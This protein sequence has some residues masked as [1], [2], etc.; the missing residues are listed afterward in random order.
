MLISPDSA[1]A[2]AAA[3]LQLNPLL[4]LTLIWTETHLQERDKE[5][6]GKQHNEQTKSPKRASGSSESATPL[7][8]IK[9][10]EWFL[11][12]IFLHSIT[13]PIF[14]I[15]EP[16]TIAV[17]A[18]LA[19]STIWLGI[20]VGRI[21]STITL[22]GINRILFWLTITTAWFPLW[23]LVLTIHVGSK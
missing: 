18:S 9:R 5:R 12:L 19:I 2:L 17:K 22:S 13:W 10:N 11:F 14:T 8:R 4:G 7:K 1:Q 3:L 23:S 20:S 21:T 16:S 6:T 15:V